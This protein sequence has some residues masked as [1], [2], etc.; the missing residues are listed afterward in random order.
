LLFRE[1]QG[2]TLAYRMFQGGSLV[3]AGLAKVIT[4]SDSRPLRSAFC[5][6]NEV[7]KDLGLSEVDESTYEIDE[8]GMTHQDKDEMI[9]STISPNDIVKKGLFYNE[10]EQREMDLLTNLFNRENYDKVQAGLEEKGMRGGLCVLFYG[11]PGTGKTEGAKQ[12]AK[13]TGRDLMIVDFSQIRSRWVGDSEKNTKR[14]F[15]EYRK[16]KSKSKEAPILLLNEADAILGKRMELVNHSSDKMENTMQNI[17]LQQMEDFD[18]IMIATTN[19]ATILDP[20]FERRFLVK[21]G[22]EKPAVEARVKIWMAMVPELTEAEALQLAETFDIAGGNME[23]VVR[24]RIMEEILFQKPVNF[25]RML[26]LC[27]EEVVSLKGSPR[28]IGF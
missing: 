21:L 3:Q 2:R 8:D 9:F 13:S 28:R 10:K 25:D 4:E 24:N 5:L 15:D 20:A 1:E 22:F 11:A 19:L 18:G 6:N 14:I 26:S 23:N 27:E 16:L 17:L 7:A 12:L